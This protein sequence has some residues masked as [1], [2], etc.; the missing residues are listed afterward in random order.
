MLFLD[1]FVV[2]IGYLLGSVSPAYILGRVLRGIDIREY[3]TRN[4]GT[5]N[6]KQVLGLGPA[7]ICGIYDFFKGLLSMFIAWKLGAP[8]IVVY[9]A[10]YAAILGHIFPFYLRF[11]GGEGQATTLGIFFF[12]IIKSILNNWFPFVVLIPVGA[13]ALFLFAISPAEIVGTFALPAFILLFLSKTQLN[14]TTVFLGLL[15]LEMW[16][17]TL[18]NVKKFK[19]LQK[20]PA[21]LKAMKFWRTSLRPLAIIF[22]ILFLYFDK[23]FMLIFVG[24]IAL[25]P[26]ILDITRLLSK[27]TNLFLFKTPLIFKQKERHT[28]SSITLFLVAIFLSILLFPKDIAILASLFL[29][30]GDV[31]GKIIGLSYGKNRIFKKTLEG[32]IAYFLAAVIFGLVFFDYLDIS[33][34]ML[35]VGALTAALTELIPWGIDDNLSVALIS[36]AVMYVMTIF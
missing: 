7:I 9:A 20:M 8:E 32:S 13:L 23:K 14:A 30:F 29:I 21:A 3:G 4:A 5:R 1:I 25:V 27:K 16:I 34:A 11:C 24:S 22:P 33:V 28:F 18:Y 36:G 2:L 12:L 17:V 6:T 31:F 15:L 35:L 19:I 26:L 10:G